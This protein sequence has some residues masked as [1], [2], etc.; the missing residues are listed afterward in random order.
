M[1]W[2]RIGHI[3][4]G[5]KDLHQSLAI[6]M[7]MVLLASNQGIPSLAGLKWSQVQALNKL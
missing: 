3:G 4:R 6:Q 5:W 2:P 7:N 1:Y